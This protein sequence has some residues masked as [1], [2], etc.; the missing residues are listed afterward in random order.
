DD[1][2]EHR[3]AN[4]CGLNGVPL[5]D[6]PPPPARGRTRTSRRNYL[7]GASPSADGSLTNC[8]LLVCG[9]A[10]F[11]NYFNCLVSIHTCPFNRSGART[12]FSLTSTSCLISPSTAT[13]CAAFPQPRSSKATAA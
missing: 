11:Y 3:C 10:S 7:A 13:S 9:R 1:R 12:T 4:A 2:E 5:P 8:V 6:L